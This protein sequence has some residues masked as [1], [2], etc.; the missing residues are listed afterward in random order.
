MR[1]LIKLNNPGLTKLNNAEYLNLSRRVWALV[2][3]T[4][5]EKLGI[6]ADVVTSYGERLD[7]L[8][9][10]VARS[11]A[12]AETPEM[13]ELEEQRDALGQYI[14]DNVRNAQ[15][16]PI[17]SKAEAG[18]ALW[19]ILKPYEKFYSL[20]NQQET[21]VINGMLIDLSKDENSPHV[22][23]LA[24]TDYVAKLSV[25]N[26]RYQMLTEQRTSQREAAKTENSKTL[27]K[28]LDVM[29]DYIT[30]VAFC[31]SVAKPTE[32]TARFITELNA[33]IAEINVLYNLRTAKGKDEEEET[34]E[35]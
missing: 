18:K 23:T 4:G 31:E 2:A 15:N 33:I 11:Y 27:R 25:V 26:S 9:D 1:T 6:E 5:A 34:P 7:L 29:Y 32:D 14:V 22:A 8:S 17:E 28:E 19:L 3:A 13:K 21:V 12:Q 16:L 20:P 10:L 30:T 24:L 35:N